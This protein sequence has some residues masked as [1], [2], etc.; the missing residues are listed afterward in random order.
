LNFKEFFFG[1]SCTCCNS[2]RMSYM[3]MLIIVFF[4][5]NFILFWSLL[6]VCFLIKYYYILLLLFFSYG[7]FEF[8][9][10]KIISSIDGEVYF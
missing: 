2:P 10:N 7:L 8:D 4:F 6:F 5:F 3:T 1:F 9:L